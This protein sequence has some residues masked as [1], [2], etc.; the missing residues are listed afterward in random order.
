MLAENLIAQNKIDGKD[1]AA[2]LHHRLRESGWARPSSGIWKRRSSYSAKKWAKAIPKIETARAV[3]RADP[4][5]AAQ[6][7]LMLAECYR[8]RG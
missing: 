4:Q 7:N 1:Q 3:L 6:L 8:P 2:E 5:L